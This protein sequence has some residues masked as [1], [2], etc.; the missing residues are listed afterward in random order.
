MAGIILIIVVTNN[1]TTEEPSITYDEEFPN[2]LC[3]I[4][5]LGTIT[6]VDLPLLNVVT[7][8]GRKEE[9]ANM[10]EKISAHKVYRSSLS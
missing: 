3:L 9:V 5:G 10:V 8:F 2:D 7:R 1:T 4:G 6:N